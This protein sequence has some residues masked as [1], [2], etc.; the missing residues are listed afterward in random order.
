MRGPLRVNGMTI[1][2]F[3]LVISIV[4]VVLIPLLGAGLTYLN[5]LRA[6]VEA[7]RNEL[8]AEIKETREELRGTLDQINLEVRKTNGR[9]GV[10]ESWRSTHD[11]VD[12]QREDRMTREIDNVRADIRHLQSTVI[13]GQKEGRP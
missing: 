12:D 5:R 4:Q 1:E 13:A 10:L 3:K 7:T 6:S 9:I 8:Q 11:H 2:H